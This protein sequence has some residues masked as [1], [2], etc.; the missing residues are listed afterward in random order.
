MEITS[1]WR[2]LLLMMMTLSLVEK[3]NCDLSEEPLFQAVLKLI[4]GLRAEVEKMSQEHKNFKN[5]LEEAFWEL[6]KEQRSLR[7]LMMNVDIHGKIDDL[8]SRVIQNEDKI[9]ELKNISPESKQ[10]SEEKGIEDPKYE[11]DPMTSSSLALVSYPGLLIVGGGSEE[12]QKTV[13]LWAPD[14]PNSWLRGVHCSLPSTLLERG[15]YHTQHG[16]LV[17]GGFDGWS[18]TTCEKFENGEWEVSH[19]LDSR[20]EGHV[21]WNSSK[22]VVLFGGRPDYYSSVLLLDEGKTQ[23][24]FDIEYTS[25]SCGISIEE[26]DSV[27]LTGGSDGGDEVS[28]VIKYNLTGMVANFPDLH[29]ARY[30]HACASYVNEDNLRV[31]LV[32]GGQQGQINPVLLSSTEVFKTGDEKWS[33]RGSLPKAI[34]ALTAGILDND[35]FLLGGCSK[36]ENRICEERENGI[37]VFDKHLG[38]W[39]E[40]GEMKQKRNHATVGVVSVAEYERYCL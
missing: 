35:I 20:R 17:C 7:V 36:Y 28:S 10:E 40:F 33:E 32:T 26:D 30:F 3:T 25:D 1:G 19:E 14:G 34:T 15:Q 12:N 11:E 27:L 9:A 8:Y 38:V 5:K 37:L 29:E 21:M 13:E 4:G 22:G 16:N 2:L 23:K 31:F 39:F 24:L 18:P 6:E